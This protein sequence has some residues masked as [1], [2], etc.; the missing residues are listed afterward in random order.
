MLHML[1]AIF[2]KNHSQLFQYNF[3][4]IELLVS[5][6]T[7]KIEP[8]DEKLEDEGITIRSLKYYIDSKA[9]EKCYRE[10]SKINSPS[11]WVNFIPSLRRRARNL[12]YDMRSGE[13]LT[14][15]EVI[16]TYF[17]ELP[18]EIK[19]DIIAL[20][21]EAYDLIGNLQIELITTDRLPLQ[22]ATFQHAL[23]MKLRHIHD[24]TKAFIL[25]LYKF[26]WKIEI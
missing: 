25:F 9:L 6:H 5:G 14:L 3:E 2:S 15:A 12:L 20:P 17:D 21:T 8:I 11:F 16:D 19:N 7:L 22:I 23:N 24:I 4:Y 13:V 26:L 18:E 10:D 1:A